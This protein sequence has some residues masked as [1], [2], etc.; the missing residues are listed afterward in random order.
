[1]MEQNDNNAVNCTWTVF[2]A[3]S[4]AYR[5]LTFENGTDVFPYG[6]GSSSVELSKRQLHVEERH[7][8]KDGHQN[9]RDEES[10]W[11]EM[12]KVSQGCCTQELTAF[13]F[14]AA[15]FRT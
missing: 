1:M 2:F 15:R 9:V 8:A 13:G 5:H 3:L 6:D 14:M 4:T 7:T 12:H 11:T 10:T